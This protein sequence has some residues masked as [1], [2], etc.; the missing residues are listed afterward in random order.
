MEGEVVSNY[1]SAPLLARHQPYGPLR[2]GWIASVGGYYEDAQAYYSVEGVPVPAG[3]ISNP[4][5][6]AV[7]VG[8]DALQLLVWPNAP[9]DRSKGCCAP[10]T[11]LPSGEIVFAGGDA[12]VSWRPGTHDFHIVSRI[13]DPAERTF[14][15][16]SWADL[17]H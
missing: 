15:I 7:S 6:A 13:V 9:G 16:A 4:E 1:G 5:L 8:D 17:S 12:L 2:R 11:W 3:T 10:A 14:A